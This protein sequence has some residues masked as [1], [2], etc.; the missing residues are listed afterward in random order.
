[1]RTIEEDLFQ[2]EDYRSTLSIG[3]ERMQYIFDDLIFHTISL[4]DYLGNLIGFI[5]KNDM[6]LKWTGLSKSANDKT[7]SLS[8]FKIASIIIRN[9]RDWVAHLYD[10]RS[11]LIHYK[12]DEVPKRMEFIFENMQQEP[13]LIFDLHIA[14]PYTFQKNVKS[15]SADF[16]KQEAS[17]LDAANWVTNRTITCFKDTV[18]CIDEEL[19]PKVEARLKEIYNKHMYEKRAGEADAKNT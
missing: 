19:T 16:D 5:Y 10:Y 8:G 6:N 11:S 18:K 7:N 1:M 15:F 4:M 2:K 13:K 12:K 9:D 3:A 14:V 17:L